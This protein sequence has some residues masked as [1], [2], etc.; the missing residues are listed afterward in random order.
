MKSSNLPL[1]LLVLG[2]VAS[3]IVNVA[4][5][6][7]LVDQAVSLD[8]RSIHATDCEKHRDSLDLVLR[9]TARRADVERV[10]AQEVSFQ[11]DAAGKYLGSWYGSSTTKGFRH[12]REP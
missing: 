6:W 7:K 8:G 5:G 3:L 4:L 1:V 9:A 12:D 2:L 10:G 11:F